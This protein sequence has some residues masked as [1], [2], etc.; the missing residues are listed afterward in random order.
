MRFHVANLQ[1]EDG[2]VI[3]KG[4]PAPALQ[5]SE[6]IGAS[7]PPA[8]ELQVSGARMKDCW[9]LIA[10]VVGV[11]PEGV[12]PLVAATMQHAE[13]LNAGMPFPSA[14]GARL[15]SL[16]NAAAAWIGF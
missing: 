1:D 5:H 3:P 4:G 9:S 13:R 6:L 11:G 14:A 7:V 8:Q 10:A 12:P 2:N 16:S 15:V